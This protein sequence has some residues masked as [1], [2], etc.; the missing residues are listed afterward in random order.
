MQNKTEISLFLGTP[1]ATPS[2]GA[3][4]VALGMD[5]RIPSFVFYALLLGDSD[6]F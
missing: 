6:L 3:T 1:S 5:E 2:N 4:A